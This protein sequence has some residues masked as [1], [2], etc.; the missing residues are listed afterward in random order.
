MRAL[1]I[2]WLLCITS[3]SPAFA[4]S[5]EKAAAPDASHPAA[6]QQATAAAPVAS[7]S[8]ANQQATAVAL[9]AQEKKQLSAIGNLSFSLTSSTGEMVSYAF[10]GSKSTPPE[11]ISWN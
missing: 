9:A 2:V 8:A 3:G 10:D 11:S 1:F 6:E 7:E 5:A 4:Q